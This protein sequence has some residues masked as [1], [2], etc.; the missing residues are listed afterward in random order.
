MVTGIDIF[1]S[2]KYEC[3]FSTGDNVD[4]PIVVK[5]EYILNFIDDDGCMALM[6]DSGEMKEVLKLPDDEWF[7]DVTDKCKEFLDEGKK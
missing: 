5:K 3:T 7:E 4:A 1:S 6:N 2:G